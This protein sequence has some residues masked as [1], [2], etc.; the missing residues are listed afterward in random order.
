M[1]ESYLLVWPLIAAFG[2]VAGVWLHSK[3]D[4]GVRPMRRAVVVPVTT[5]KVARFV[6]RR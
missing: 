6:P 4:P 2:T 5:T 3:V 1:N